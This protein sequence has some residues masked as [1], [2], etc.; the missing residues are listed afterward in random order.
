M[1]TRISPQ[2]L[3]SRQRF[4]AS[5]TSLGDKCHVVSLRP[6]GRGVRV[7]P[8]DRGAMGVAAGAGG[9]RGHG[10]G[11]RMFGDWIEGTLGEGSWG[12]R[13]FL[14]DLVWELVEL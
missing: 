3:G 7:G 11:R 6:C 8:G 4:D 14:D 10:P 1:S 12:K 9:G 13:R 2:E 5:A